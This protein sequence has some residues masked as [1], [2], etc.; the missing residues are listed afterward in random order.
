MIEY[1]K[2]RNYILSKLKFETYP[3]N[4][5]GLRVA[6]SLKSRP[7]S[8]Q[9][10][11]DEQF[12]AFY[13]TQIEA[14]R[15]NPEQELETSWRRYG[16][17]IIGDCFTTD[18]NNL[19]HSIEGPAEYLGT[20]NTTAFYYKGTSITR[21]YAFKYWIPETTRLKYIQDP[22]WGKEIKDSFLL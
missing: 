2:R 7:N 22:I 3:T 10:D 16:N 18:E 21:A 1:S 6:M 5:I 14:Y 4:V 19:L 8:P 9:I 13:V 15:E 17:Y 11:I 12:M 20:S